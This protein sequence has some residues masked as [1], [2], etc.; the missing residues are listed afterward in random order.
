MKANAWLQLM[1]IAIESKAKKRLICNAAL[2]T[3]PCTVV[4]VLVDKQSVLGCK[5]M[6]LSSPTGRLPIGQSSV[7]LAA[8]QLTDWE[9]ENIVLRL[10]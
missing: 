8:G 3:F 10:R 6:S 5:T 2:F 1:G 4:C 7:A 9:R